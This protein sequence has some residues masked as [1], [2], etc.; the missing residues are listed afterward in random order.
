MLNK[1]DFLMFEFIKLNTTFVRMLNAYLEM[2]DALISL[3]ALLH[4]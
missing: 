2:S 3:N 1:N 4:Q